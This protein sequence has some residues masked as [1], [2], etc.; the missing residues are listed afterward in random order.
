[1]RGR[2]QYILVI[3][4]MFSLYFLF[5]HSVKLYGKEA[6]VTDVSK[7]KVFIDHLDIENDKGEQQVIVTVINNSHKTFSGMLKLSSIGVN[8]EYL[9]FEAL[10]LT[11]FPGKTE[12][13]TVWLKKSLV[14]H[15]KT[16]ILN[17]QFSSFE[18]KIS[19]CIPTPFK[20]F[21]V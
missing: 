18:P 21:F 15:I 20:G 1:M 13:R 17:P 6:A 8:N 11:V 16:E 9:T 12:S 14:P 7:I 2:W 3:F 19:F 10:Y 5:A 4:I